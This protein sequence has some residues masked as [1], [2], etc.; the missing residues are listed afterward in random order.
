MRWA[1]QLRLGN[2][3]APMNVLLAGAPSTAKTDLALLTAEKAQVATY[4]LVSP[5]GSLVGQ[6]ERR[7]RLQFRIFKQLGPAFGFI[8]EISEAFPMERGSANL[9][10]GASSSVTAEMLNAL[11]DSSRAGKTI[12]VATTNCPWRIGAAMSSRFLFVPVL[13][14][15]EE[16]YPEILAS[17]AG[18]LF[19][20]C[21]FANDDAVLQD[22]ARLFFQKGATPRVMRS[23]IASKFASE[24]ESPS[25]RLLIAAARACAMQDP[26]DRASAEYADLFA[27]RVCSNLEMLPWHGQVSSYPF[28]AYLRGIVS[29]ADGGIDLDALNHR[30]EQLAPQVNV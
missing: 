24:E 29:V 12:L 28:P 11:S 30:I 7:V 16:D 4:G 18:S 23:L 5:K 14:A 25:S 6:T 22:A 3:Y 2:P 1:E 21:S 10:S 20:E 26:R 19:P 17:I 27:I 15:I 8:D 13:S 9:D